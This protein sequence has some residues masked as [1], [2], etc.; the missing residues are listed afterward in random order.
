MCSVSRAYVITP[1]ACCAVREKIA[2]LLFAQA[3]E[4][5][6]GRRRT[7]RAADAEGQVVARAHCIAPQRF[8]RAT[9]DVVAEYHC[10]QEIVAVRVFALGHRKRRGDGAAAG[11]YAR[12]PVGIVGLVGVREHAVRKRRVDGRGDD[13]AADDLRLRFA[14]LLLDVAQREDA[15]LERGPGHHGCNRVEDMV[16]RLRHHGRRNRLRSGVGHVA[17]Q[18]GSDARAGVRHHGSPP[19]GRRCTLLLRRM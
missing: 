3:R 8:R 19:Y 10:A 18:I 11:M 12:G 6:R 7:H 14:A 1:D 9:A 2:V 15:G 17:D 13:A 4:I 5:A 16:L